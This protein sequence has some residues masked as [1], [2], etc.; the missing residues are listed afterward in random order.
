M[1]GLLNKNIMRIEKQINELEKEVWSFTVINNNIFLNG[2]DYM[3]KE[4]KR[5]RKYSSVKK[6]DRIMKRVCSIQESEV[7]FTDEIRQ[8]AINEYIK[9]I[10]CLK[11]SERKY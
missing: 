10:N 8:Q 3:T 1:Y 11:W 5:H 9:T 6:Y 2:Y 7:P 4:S